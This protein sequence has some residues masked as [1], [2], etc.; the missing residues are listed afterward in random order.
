M[1]GVPADLPL[2]MFEN[3]TLI[4][5]CLGEFQLQFH[6]QTGESAW[7]GPNGPEIS[8]EGGWEL[9]DGS[10]GIVDSSHPNAERESYRLHRLLGWQVVRTEVDPPRSFALE[11]DGGHVLRVFED[12]EQ[13]ESFSI[14]PGSIFV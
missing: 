4:Q 12:S 1:H 7:P 11:F 8:V 14:Q 2:A 9:R 13:F 10:G 5:V 3:A 6:F